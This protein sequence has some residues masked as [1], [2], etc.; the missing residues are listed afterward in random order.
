M[1]SWAIGWIYAIVRFACFVPIIIIIVDLVACTDLQKRFMSYFKRMFKPELSKTPEKF[2]ITEH[3]ELN[4]GVLLITFKTHRPG[5]SINLPCGK[6]IRLHYTEMDG[7]QVKRPYTPIRY[8]EPGSFQILM[9][10]YENGKMGNYLKSR[11]AGD[12]IAISGPV[13][14]MSYLGGG[15]FKSP[16]VELKVS[17]LCLVAGGTGLTPMFQILDEVFNNK[18]DKLKVYLI[19]AASTEKDIYLK[20]ELNFYN[21][22]DRINVAFCVSNP[23]E[24][25][26]DRVPNGYGSRISKEIFEEFFWAQLFEA[27]VEINTVAA[28]YCGPPGFEKACK[29]LFAGQGFK[30]GL[31]LFRW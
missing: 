4:D 15:V 21:R 8:R 24:D 26:E 22:D 19:Y 31:D 2:T 14:G 30:A 10:V 11:K 17:C 18:S 9:K 25:F 3:K 23:E 27:K 13:G 1:I 16:K 12:Q 7:S 6:H 20:K 5:R 28:G 29:E